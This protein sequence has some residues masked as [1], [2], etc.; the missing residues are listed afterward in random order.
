VDE[1]NIQYFRPQSL[2]ELEALIGEHD[3]SFLFLTG[4]DYNAKGYQDGDVLID[5]QD[6]QMDSIVEEDGFI[7]IGGLVPLDALFKED[8]LWADFR[9]ALRIEGGWNIRNGL[10]LDN[11]LRVANGRSPL[12][13][14]LRALDIN[15]FVQPEGGVMA[16]DEY[17]SDEYNWRDYFIE[18]VSLNKPKAVAYEQVAR[19]PK[20]LPIVNVAVVQDQDDTI[21][22]TVGGHEALLGGL[23]FE[24]GTVIETEQVREL[25]VDTDDAWASAEY[26][27]DVAES[28][29]K[30]C[31]AKLGLA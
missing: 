31:I 18:K 7:E 25:F 4:G 5:L 6:L 19:S 24:P 2:D 23:L 16:L 11:F 10:S 30:R 20:D 3:G 26:R 22:V 21:V 13:T 28:L 14:C 12:L 29:L 8:A 1:I 15:L 17:L 9:D 27:Q